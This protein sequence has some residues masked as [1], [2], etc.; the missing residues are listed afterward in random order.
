[1]A[2]AQR[3]RKGEPAP[4]SGDHTFAKLPFHRAF[5]ICDSTDEHKRNSAPGK[6]FTS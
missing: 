1:M 5:L 4:P 2:V 6:S 3:K